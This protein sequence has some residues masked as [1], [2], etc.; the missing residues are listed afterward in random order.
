MRKKY[1]IHY[2]GYMI[3]KITKNKDPCVPRNIT[4]VAARN[5]GQL[6][7]FESKTSPAS[8]Q[9]Q[10]FKDKASKARLPQ[11]R[12]KKQVI[13]LTRTSKL[14]RPGAHQNIIM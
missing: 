5:K 13:C 9:R 6:E 8:F 14:P 10:D 1:W 11:P 12:L 3:F 7:D 2:E 4:G